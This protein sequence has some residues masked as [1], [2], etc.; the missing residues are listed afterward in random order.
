[1]TSDD[2][3]AAPTAAGLPPAEQERLAKILDDYLVAAERGAPVAPD[4]LLKRHPADAEYLRC[5]LSG[6]QLFHEAVRESNGAAAAGHSLQVIGAGQTIADFSLLREIGRGGMGVVYE[7]LQ[8]S[9]RRR[10]ALK[11][12]PFSSAHD[13]KQ[14]GRFR[15]EA[16]AAA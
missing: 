5:Y 8:T 10:V 15:N 6:L 2:F 14:I 3:S 16:Q 12:L 11:V 7:A 9:L 4:E 1:M 13:E